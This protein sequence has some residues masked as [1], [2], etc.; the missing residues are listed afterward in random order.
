[1]ILEKILTKRIVYLILI[2]VGVG[3]IFSVEAFAAAPNQTTRRVVTGRVLDAQGQPVKGAEVQ[4]A[5]TMAAASEDRIPKGESLE[6]GEFIL[7]IGAV[8]TAS[9]KG[10]D[11]D[12]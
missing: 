4:L 9:R 5:P 10:F 3:L 6:T 7:Y 8:L 2:L 11:E 1:M 12:A